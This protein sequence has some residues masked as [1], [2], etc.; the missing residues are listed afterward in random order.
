[1]QH[2]LK[3]QTRFSSRSN[4]NLWILAHWSSLFFWNNSNQ[5]LKSFNMTFKY[6]NINVIS[7]IPKIINIPI[8]RKFQYRVIGIYKKTIIIGIS[9]YRNSLPWGTRWKYE[10]KRPILAWTKELNENTNKSTIE[11]LTGL[12][13]GKRIWCWRRSI[14]FCHMLI[15]NK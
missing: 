2:Q 15:I 8:Y 11:R 7:I 6:T 1:L 4:L 10:Q 12:G 13:F 9:I 3:K 14:Q 5:H